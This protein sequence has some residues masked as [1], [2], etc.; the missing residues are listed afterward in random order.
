M[1]KNLKIKIKN[2]QIAAAVSLGGLKEKLA[3]K[4]AETPEVQA[5]PAA[6]TPKEVK[7]TKART[8]K[9]T[10]SATPIPEPE[11][12]VSTE[13][14]APRAR[15]RS[16]SVFA[17]PQS[18]AAKSLDTADGPPAIEVVEEPPIVEAVTPIQ[19]APVESEP[20]T[21]EVAAP[22]VEEPKIEPPK[23]AVPAPVEK[24]YKRPEP[25]PVY[26]RA[27]SSP[28]QG[29]N[30]ANMVPY[31]RLGPTGRHVR[32]LIP[33]PPP[34]K[35]KPKEAPGSGNTPR[36][37]AEETAARERAAARPKPGQSEESDDKKKSGGGGGGG[38]GG[39]AGSKFKE[40]KDVKPTRV[41][42]D[43]PTSFDSRAR[44][45]L[46]VDEEQ[47]QWRRRRHKGSRH[48][49]ET[50]TIRPTTLKV[51]L[52]ITLKDLAGEMKLKG[53]QLM[54]KLLIQGVAATIN[55]YLDDP[56]IVMLLGHEFGCEITIDTS[57]TER[58][59]ITDKTIKE[60]IAAS[61]SEEIT[62]RPPVVT[63]MGHVDHGKT[64]LI[65]AIRKSNR[66][67]GEA[68]AITQHIG[69]FQC[70]TAIGNL[71]VIDTPGHEAFSA[72]RARGA[73]VTDIVV[74]VVAG[75]EG[76][77][78]QTIEAIQHAK[79]AGVTIVVALNKC[80]KPN[81]NPENVYRQL[82]EQELLPESWGGQTITVNCSAVTG[83]GIQALLE[84]LALQAE[85]LELRANP[86][87]RA[88]GAVIEVELHKGLGA[89]ASV[90][91]QNGTLRPGDAIVFDQYWGRI[92]TMRDDQGN[93]V[94]EAPP[95][96][97]V[98]ITGL[99]GLPS[100]GQEFIV[101]ANEREAREIAEARMQEKQHTRLQQ[102][103]KPM[104]VEGLM[105]KTADSA[106]KT[107]NII[108]RADVRGS[109]EAVKVALEKIQ[110]NKVDLSII[111]HGVG[112]ISESDIQMA[113]TSGAVVLGFHTQIE[114]HADVLVRQLGVK[115]RQHDVIF[116]AIDDVKELMGGLLDKIEQENEKGKAEVK[117][118]FKSSHLGN[119]AG[120]IVT[121]GAIVR[122][123]RMRV[124]R[125]GEMLWK[126]AIS[127]L[128][129]VNEDVREIQK[130]FEC[131]IVLSGFQA[132]Q[133]G[134]ILEAYEVTYITQEL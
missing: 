56:T 131:G 109:L 38:G 72:M 122:N 130:G 127:S 60:E 28:R 120:C 32:D 34:V 114:S 81:F 23:A 88:R 77:R 118:V 52:P 42:Q 62:L 95:S 90:L 19:E 132:V 67:A 94:K 76:I 22:V 36:T 73:D 85:V 25:T 129:R 55:D 1:A 61:E 45:G 24:P 7:T 107:L 133:V 44:Q 58:I 16:R 11:V 89:T 54:E 112:E 80:D 91:I 48:V 101:V 5:T 110:S 123:N 121:E 18:E 6:E 87:A 17:D 102:A 115:V 79:S 106:K 12:E 63:F 105:A 124:M 47:N 2:E 64:S 50:V 126:G 86:K 82:A 119:I 43:S 100:S 83:E 29:P 20:A 31:E 51:R 68:G 92:K 69:A 39:G 49:Q 57:E 117:A 10:S 128:R 15:A 96:M 71:T 9:A 46:R 104:T 3:K 99:S 70:H 93:D 75:D 103:V 116:H 41:K 26:T 111:F 98:E 33:P 37:A 30:L 27:F 40:Y 21:V 8:K 84:M 4:K 97:P 78:A 65:D 53:A 59:R 35:E 113:A 74:L 14:K 66:A 134:D 125:N 108:L 13:A